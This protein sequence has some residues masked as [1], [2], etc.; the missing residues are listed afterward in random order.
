MEWNGKL[1][2]FMCLSVFDLH[3]NSVFF[4]VAPWS[5]QKPVFG[6]AAGAAVIA[7]CATGR[8]RSDLA[9]TERPWII[10]TSTDRRSWCCKALVPKELL[11]LLEVSIGDL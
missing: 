4:Q 8:I 10:P 11:G 3:A 6:G 2:F 1:V 7:Y 5:L 9:N